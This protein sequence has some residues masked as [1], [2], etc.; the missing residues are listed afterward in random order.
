MF[1]N[2]TW[3]VRA[4]L[5]LVV[6]RRQLR[7]IQQCDHMHQR[8]IP[9]SN[10]GAE[11]ETSGLRLLKNTVNMQPFRVLMLLSIL[12]CSLKISDINNLTFLVIKRKE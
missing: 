10:K 3:C 9:C 11:L 4:R 6:T 12:M 7:N 5:P 1:G 8:P 2:I